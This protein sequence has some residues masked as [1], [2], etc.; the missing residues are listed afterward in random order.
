[1]SGS[2]ENRDRNERCDEDGNLNDAARQPARRG[3]RH[4]QGEAD[5]PAGRPVNAMCVREKPSVAEKNT[6]TMTIITAGG[7]MIPQ[8]PASALEQAA[9]STTGQES[10]FARARTRAIWASIRATSLRFV[11]AG[12]D[13]RATCCHS[14]VCLSH[15]QK[16]AYSVSRLCSIPKSAIDS[17]L[18][19]VIAFVEPV[20]GVLN[21]AMY[22]IA[23]DGGVGFA[24]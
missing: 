9:A 11:S 22:A 15:L 8:K 20:K 17:S 4:R 2:R 5:G 18:V 7:K 3:Y 13:W 21:L 14:S 6:P 19:S 23:S 10:A 16:S 1:M 24:K 12:F